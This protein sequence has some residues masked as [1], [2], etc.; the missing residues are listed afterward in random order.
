M[1]PRSARESRWKQG[2]G[3]R[4]AGPPGV[5]LGRPQPSGGSGLGLGLRVTWI[6]HWNAFT[7]P[8]TLVVRTLEKFGR[9]E[10]AAEFPPVSPA[11]NA[12]LV[13][14]ARAERRLIGTV[15][16]PAGV[17]LVGVLRR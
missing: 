8:A 13:A 5:R 3:A 4:A 9:R 14:V 11:V 10:R 12:L 2:T 15:G 6:T 1:S 16:L 17:S 7:L